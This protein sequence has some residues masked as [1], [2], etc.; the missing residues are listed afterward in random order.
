MT[1][2]LTCVIASV[3]AAGM[4]ASCLSDPGLGSDGYETGERDQRVEVGILEMDS[5][6]VYG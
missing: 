2:W 3:V 6:E 5:G 4:T 1:D